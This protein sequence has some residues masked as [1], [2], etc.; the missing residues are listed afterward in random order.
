[1]HSLIERPFASMKTWKVALSL[2]VI[3]AIAAPAIAG[4]WRLEPGR[5]VDLTE[6]EKQRF[7]NFIERNDNCTYRSPEWIYCTTAQELLSAGGQYYPPE[8]VTWKYLARNFYV[9]GGAFVLVFALVM[10]GP[11]YVAWLRR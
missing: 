6:G 10:I 8:Q 11:R 2:A 4:T 5:W 1:M 3:A 9:S 7:S